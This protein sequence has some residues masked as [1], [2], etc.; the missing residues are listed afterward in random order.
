[1]NINIVKPFDKI[2]FIKKSKDIDFDFKKEYVVSRIKNFKIKGEF[3]Q[4][5]IFKNDKNEE[6]SFNSKS[7]RFIV[8]ISEEEITQRYL[9]LHWIEAGYSTIINIFFTIDYIDE[10]KENIKLYITRLKK[11]AEN[12]KTEY[13]NR[14]IDLFNNLENYDKDKLRLEVENYMDSTKE[15]ARN[16]KM[17]IFDLK[18]EIKIDEKDSFYENDDYD[19]EKNIMDSFKNG[20]QD[21]FGY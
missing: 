11:I 7:E 5:I 15:L 8:K 21:L 3:N 16:E 1:M 2:V 18:Y 19:E 20:T 9:E 12:S 13:F 10:E 17:I 4:T 14:L 6:I